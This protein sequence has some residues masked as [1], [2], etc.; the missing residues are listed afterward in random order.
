MLDSLPFWS[1]QT[2]RRWRSLCSCVLWS[3]LSTTW[4]DLF[5]ALCKVPWFFVIGWQTEKTGFYL[6]VIF[7]QAFSYKQTLLAMWIS[8]FSQDAEQ[9]ALFTFYVFTDLDKVSVHKHTKILSPSKKAWSNPYL[10]LFIF[11]HLS[12]KVL[13]L[14][15]SFVAL[16]VPTTVLF[17][18]FF[19]RKWERKTMAMKSQLSSVSDVFIWF[20]L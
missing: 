18:D 12:N 16:T 20:S 7:P 10:I 14:W 19:V 6:S 11:M 17:E 15:H 3:F 5:P 8:Y 1:K 13:L 9:L 4:S 2:T